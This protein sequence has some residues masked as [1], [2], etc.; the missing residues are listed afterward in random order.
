M[1]RTYNVVLRRVHV[2][3]VAVENQYV[4]YILSVSVA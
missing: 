2:T 1:R 4:L 3:I